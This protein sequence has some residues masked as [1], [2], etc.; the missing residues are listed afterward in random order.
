[1]TNLQDII[2]VNHN[3]TKPK[4]NQYSTLEEVFV[5]NKIQRIKVKDI[6]N[7]LFRF[8]DFKEIVAILIENNY[9]IV[10]G[11]LII[12]NGKKFEYSYDNWSII[13]GDNLNI[14]NQKALEFEKQVK[15]RL[16]LL[17]LELLYTDFVIK[18]L[19]G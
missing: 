15:S 5:K 7:Q 12:Q 4:T 19:H 16:K 3:I 18:P 6:H 2:N 9:L 13:D 11:D 17:D 10:G 8:V 1:M 14:S